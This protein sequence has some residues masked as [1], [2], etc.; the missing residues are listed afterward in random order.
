MKKKVYLKIILYNLYSIKANV[1]QT[2]T[3]TVSSIIC[4]VEIQVLHQGKRFMRVKVI[5]LIIVS[6]VTK[7][8]VLAKMPIMSEFHTDRFFLTV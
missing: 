8:V 4:H 2:E 7:T 3:P 1:S 5:D 6:T